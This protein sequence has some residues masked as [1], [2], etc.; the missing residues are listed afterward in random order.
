MHTLR[1]TEYPNFG[2]GACASLIVEFGKEHLLIG[3]IKAYHKG[4]EDYR[5]HI[6]FS[7]SY[8]AV[9]AF[10]VEK[11]KQLIGADAHI[12]EKFRSR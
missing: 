4:S 2:L 7:K 11:V 3:R 12:S 6:P 8:H 5:H 9:L 10:P 1:V